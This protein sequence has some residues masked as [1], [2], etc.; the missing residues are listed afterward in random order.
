MKLWRSASTRSWC[1]C[2]GSWSGG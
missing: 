2:G 1:R